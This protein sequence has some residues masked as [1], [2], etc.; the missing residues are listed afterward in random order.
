MSEVV[1]QIYLVSQ[2]QQFSEVSQLQEMAHDWLTLCRI[3]TTPELFY[4]NNE[5]EAQPFELA[6]LVEKINELDLSGEAEITFALKSSEAEFSLQVYKGCMR[7]RLLMDKEIFLAKQKI[8]VDY[9]DGRMEKH[10]LYAYIRVLEE[11]LSHNTQSLAERQ[12]ESLT[13]PE[14]LPKMYGK[15]EEVIVDVSQLGGY[16]FYFHGLCFTACWKMWF[17]RPY[18]HIIPKK[19]F[20]DVQQVQQAV[21]L[22]NEVVKITLH[23]DP[24]QW[25]LEPNSEFQMLF[26]N[27][28]G[29]DQLEWSNGVGILREPYTEFI[30]LGEKTQ[31][32]QYQNESLQPTVKSR[33]RHFTTRVF[34][35]RQEEYLEGRRF[36][37]LNNRAYFPWQ[38]ET[39]KTML[40]Y[41]IINPQHM[42]DLGVGAFEFYI[43]QYLNA[44]IEIEEGEDFRAIL[45]FY[46]PKESLPSIPLEVIS[47]TFQQKKVAVKKQR[48]T[49]NRGLIQFESSERDLLVEFIDVNELQQ[50][51]DRKMPEG[52]RVKKLL[53][54]VRDFVADLKKTDD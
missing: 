4:F 53:T 34:S 6:P 52:S 25:R 47:E 38:D 50:V 19:A 42:L 30:Q 15:D 23:E 13:Y 45:R 18:Y 12:S 22:K 44:P 21:E 7:E 1:D 24:F 16:D 29:F 2:L 3:L 35:L 37:Q 28:L 11:Y 10:G 26:R 32:I 51:Q 9:V 40:A 43:E 14:D 41:W 31:M 36:G 5:A 33:A 54:K 39:K 17:G 27:Q 48:Q 20:L 8:I 49:K 46:V